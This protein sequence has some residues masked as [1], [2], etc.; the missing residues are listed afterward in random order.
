VLLGVAVPPFIQ[1]IDLSQRLYDEAVAPLMRRHAPGLPYAAGL[2]GAG[3]DV[4]GYDTERSTDH[5]WG[6]RLMLILRER[7]IAT[8]RQPLDDLFRTSLPRTVAGYPTSFIESDEEPGTTHMPGEDDE[9]PVNHRIAIVTASEFLQG[10]LGID[11]T[12]GLDPAAWLTLPMQGL[13]EVTAGRVFRDDTGEITRMRNA[14]AW[15][16]DD[17]WRYL[18]AS[19]WGHIDQLE[20][21]IGRCAEVGD[22]IGS[23]LVAMYLVRGVMRLAFLMERRYWPY[24]KWFGT[25]FGRLS[26]AP[27]LQPHL[28]RARFA[29]EW[30][31]REAGVVA[32]AQALAHHHNAMGWTD[33]VDPTPRDFFN[34]PF[35]VLFAGRFGEALMATVTD[36]V[37]RA[38]PPNL[39]AIDQ[40]IDATDAF[41][42]PGLHH[43]IREWLRRETSP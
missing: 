5:D 19:Q 9:A 30:R 32:A 26:L 11:D 16:P 2:L 41:N 3:S 18:M 17:T 20:P 13:L 6:P 33:P 15:Y 8:W 4:L 34:R 23:H 25:A 21:F 39:G 1:G 36:P 42:Q 38:L 35:T 24:P 31:E 14:L 28:D 27:A 40:Y 10:R 22:D 7:D 43:A 12:T 29:R 37:V